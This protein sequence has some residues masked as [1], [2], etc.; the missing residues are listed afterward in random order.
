MFYFF[1]K[2]N[3]Q[4]FI[5]A[6]LLMPIFEQRLSF[7]M[8]QHADRGLEALQAPEWV[9]DRALKTPLKNFGFFTC[10]RQINSLK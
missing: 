10:G 8:L 3:K 2:V 4:A 6:L 7:Q 5:Q 9:H 1:E